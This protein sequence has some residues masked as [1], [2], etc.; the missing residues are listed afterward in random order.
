MLHIKS[1]VVG[2]VLACL[3]I[4]GHFFQPSA[5]SD[6]HLRVL[7]KESI[8]PTPTFPP[9]PNNKAGLCFALNPKLT[10]EHSPGRKL[11]AMSWLLNLSMR[12]INVAS[13][14]SPHSST[15]LFLDLEDS[16]K[17]QQALVDQSAF[18]NVG[19]HVTPSRKNI[20]DALSNCSHLNNCEA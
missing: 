10:E 16:Y 3:L 5:L 12:S 19:L 13:S 6:L 2:F 8:P 7:T 15:F 4:V 17:D 9:P 1:A 18:P 14:R 20:I 11:A